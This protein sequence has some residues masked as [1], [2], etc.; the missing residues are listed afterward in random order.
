M[1]ERKRFFFRSR[2]HEFTWSQALVLAVKWQKRSFQYSK[3]IVS[4]RSGNQSKETE[5]IHA[6]SDLFMSFIRL[7]KTGIK[8]R[9]DIP[10]Q[11]AHTAQQILE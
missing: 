9:A 10:S 1:S 8:L 3:N 7:E 6:A 4:T 2:G 11:P 5:I